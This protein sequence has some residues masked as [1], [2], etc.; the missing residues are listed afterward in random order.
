MSGATTGELPGELTCRELV[1]LV[2][3]YL[4]N[5]LAPDE[6]TR[7]ELHLAV[8]PGCE[9]HVQTLRAT[10]RAAGRLSEESLPEE[11]RTR[12]LRAFR[13]WKRRPPGAA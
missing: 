2:T 7:F 13:D 8:C 12:L 4:E 9:A 1:E 10:L 11:A 3:E 5:A 6:R